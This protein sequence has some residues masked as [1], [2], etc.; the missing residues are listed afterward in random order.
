M[1]TVGMLR[2]WHIK[3]PRKISRLIEAIESSMTETQHEV[4][5]PKPV[6]ELRGVELKNFCWRLKNETRNNR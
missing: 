6:R 1:S 4:K 5:L 3:N 2:N